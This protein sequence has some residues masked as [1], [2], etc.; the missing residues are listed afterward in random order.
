MTMMLLERPIVAAEPLL[1]HIS[2][3]V[4]NRMCA[5]AAAIGGRMDPTPG[6]MTPELTGCLTMPNAGLLVAGTS[7]R[8]PLLFP[9]G[10]A[11]Y[12][13][14]GLEVIL[15]RHDVVRG[16]TYDLLLHDHAGWLCRYQA[17][18]MEGDLWLVPGVGTA[19]SVRATASGV[20]ICAEPPFG[21]AAERKLGLTQLV[22]APTFARRA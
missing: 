20:E 22:L 21:D 1:P 8:R 5:L 18:Q 10:E 6:A 9:E 14:S 4:K 11:L 15:V 17:W 16:T 12:A 19:P 2:Q 13:R 7:C 3:A